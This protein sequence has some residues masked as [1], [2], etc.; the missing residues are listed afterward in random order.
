[1]GDHQCGKVIAVDNFI[2]NVQNLCCCFRVKGCSVLIQKEKLR[3]LKGSHQKG[4]RLSLASGEKTY[5][6]SQTIL[7]T[8]VQDFQ[9]LFVLST[10][11]LCDS[12]A[13][14]PCF[15]AALGKS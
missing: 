14:K 12:G 9:K 10:L 15:A 11:C 4:K 3:F 8:K 5:L 7:K 13:E 6:G 1:M 2:C